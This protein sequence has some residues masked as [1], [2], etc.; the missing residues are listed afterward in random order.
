[1]RNLPC[2]S[3]EKVVSALQEAGYT[4]DEEDVAV[5]WT[6]LGTDSEGKMDLKEF[7][8]MCEE[9]SCGQVRSSSVAWR[10][11]SFLLQRCGL[12]DP[13]RLLVKENLCIRPRSEQVRICSIC[14]CWRYMFFVVEIGCA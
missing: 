4:L 6:G 5:L 14:T 3:A 10:C 1:M 8:S 12:T 13:H 9:M 11:I 2:P 7:M